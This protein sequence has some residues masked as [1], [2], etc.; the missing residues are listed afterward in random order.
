MENLLGTI[1]IFLLA[2]VFAFL[3][4]PLTAAADESVEVKEAIVKIYTES[5]SPYY[6]APWTMKSASS[7]TGSGCVI[8]G[9]R[10]LT[11]AHVVSDQTLIQVRRNGDAKRYKARVLFVSHE[12]DLALLT[13]DDP[14]FFIGVAP[15]ELGS[16]PETQ[17]DVQ[18]YGFPKGGD[19]LSI[20]KGVISRIEHQT[21]S[22]SFIS[23]LAVQIDAAIN[24]GNSGG[25]AVI[26]N[27]I[28]GIAMQ[29]MNG[30]E[31][32]GY[33]V[34]P[35]VIAHFLKDVED[36]E[37]DGFPGLGVGMQN[38]ENPDHKQ[39]YDMSERQTG[40]LVTRVL[41]GSP[42]ENKLREKD[43]LLSVD[44]HKIA[45]N[46]TVEFRFR[47]RTSYTYYIQSR[48][49]GETAELEVLREGEI[50][51][52]QVKLDKPVQDFYLVPVEYDVMPRYYV[53]GGLVFS[54]LT[55]NYLQSWGSKWYKDASK[56]LLSILE[57]NYRSEGD[58]EVVLL[59]KVLAS[60]VNEGY[61]NFED[62]VI[63]KVNGKEIKNLK[64]L[65]EIVEHETGGDEFVVFENSR[66][67]EIVLNKKKA[68]ES[69][70]EILE[71]YHVSRDRSSDLTTPQEA[72]VD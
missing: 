33:I 36:G 60:G 27:Q 72:R 54:P 68:E 9:S 34:P 39:R 30:S 28:V 6:F 3:S 14:G 59:I 61:H 44:G 45:D 56:E 50:K 65:V 43:V 7:S 25:P 17:Q 46:G 62:W 58:K 71:T 32:I 52:L 49:M 47:E 11:N 19:T 12:T 40:L 13:V 55:L 70:K 63:T 35:P 67:K 24:S 41:P 57:S 4:L 48:Q 8:G 29:S 53:F 22:H 10:I 23:F 42:A 66:G 16:L 26:S 5:I 69:K 64:E 15:L 37:Y 51:T 2:V 1:R 20:T 18:V 38:I 21:Y 31:S